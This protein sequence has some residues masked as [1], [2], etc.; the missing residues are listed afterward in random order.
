MASS[1]APGISRRAPSCVRVLSKALLWAATVSR[2]E[3][4][5]LL[6]S[7]IKQRIVEAVR[8]KLRI[9]QAD[10]IPQELKEGAAEQLIAPETLFGVLLQIWSEVV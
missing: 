2:P 4:P 3:K 1:V 7:A 6:P 8:S 5:D 10:P 9:P